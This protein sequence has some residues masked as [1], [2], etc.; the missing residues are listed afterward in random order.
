MEATNNTGAHA[1]TQSSVFFLIQLRAFIFMSIL[2]TLKGS[3]AQ[4][5]DKDYEKES[6]FR[7]FKF[8]NKKNVLSFLQNK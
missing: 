2:I 8:K 4:A 7:E 1:V 6:R 3:Q 5:F